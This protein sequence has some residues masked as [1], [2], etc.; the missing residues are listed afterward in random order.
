MKFHHGKD[1]VAA[2]V[3]FT[4]DR[5]LAEAPWSPARAALNTIDEIV[6]VD[7]YTVRFDFTGP[8]SLAVDTLSLHQG[9]IVPSDIAPAPLRA[10]R[11]RHRAVPTRRA[12]AEREHCL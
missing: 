8:N 12:C 3:K 5:L 10:R 1:F 2:D 7:D 9:A 4:F 6:V 11:V